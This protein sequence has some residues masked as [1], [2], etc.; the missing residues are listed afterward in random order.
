MNRAFF[1]LFT[2]LIMLV[3]SSV[4]AEKSAIDTDSTRQVLMACD[5]IDSTEGTLRDSAV[6]LCVFR[7]T[8]FLDGYQRGADHGVGVALIH[9]ERASSTIKGVADLTRRAN[10]VRS[11]ARCLPESYDLD[12][13][14]AIWRAYVSLSQGAMDKPYDATLQEAIEAYF[15]R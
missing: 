1:Y 15:C 2:C 3:A 6:A 5:H 10:I 12:K 7:V 11:R 14:V 4:R 13:V 9:D 8:G